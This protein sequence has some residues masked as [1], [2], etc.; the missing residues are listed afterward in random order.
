VLVSLGF[1]AWHVM[2][3][4][5]QIVI[6]GVGVVSP[7]GIGADAF[8]HAIESQCSGIAQPIPPRRAD[9][10]VTAA[11]EVRDFDPKEYVR[12]RKSLKVMSRDSQFAVAAADMACAQ[13]GVT[14][15]TLDT[16]RLGVVLGADRIRYTIDEIAPAYAACLV[17][18]RFDASLW[19]TRGAEATYP[20][21]L[22]KVLPNM[23]A[24]HVS[25]VRDARG[26]NNT[27]QQ[28]E[29]SSLLAVAEAARVLERGAADMMITGGTSSRLHV[30]DWVRSYMTDRLSRRACDPAAACRPFDA[31]RDG[32]VRGEG[33]AALILESRHHAEARGAAILGQILGCGAS[34]VPTHNGHPAA[35]ASLHRAIQ[36]A[37]ADADITARDVGHVNA[38]G[39]STV[40]DDAAEASV[41][42]ELLPDVP[43]TAPKSYF[44]NLLA[45]TGAVELLASLLA[46][47]RGRIPA[48]LNYEEPDPACPIRVVH[49]RPMDC[50]SPIAL[51][52]NMTSIGQAAALVLGGPGA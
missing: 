39:L 34:Y 16:E 12:P 24:C 51:I 9:L 52:V 46:L 48:T 30:L 27:I 3:R 29:I 33:A 28:A 36:S 47:A 15:D 32:T 18:G 25:I 10:P 31:L 6:T 2:S 50:A 5:P 40:E 4:R 38:H 44:G 42:A 11:G 37:L 26:P 21:G 22:L 43:V 14:V 45:G 49:G 35:G 17:D 20:L 41:L 7:I 8:W 19:P 1:R 23:P 13:A